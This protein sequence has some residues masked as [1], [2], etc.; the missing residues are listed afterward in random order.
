MSILILRR[1][2]CA[3]STTGS[4]VFLRM[5]LFAYASGRFY[6]FDKAHLTAIS[7]LTKP[8]FDNLKLIYSSEQ[9]SYFKKKI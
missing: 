2:T 6:Y 3:R 7:S 8:K 5:E 1:D 4:V 9:A